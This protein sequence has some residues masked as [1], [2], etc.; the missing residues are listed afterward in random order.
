MK[1]PEE[2]REERIRERERERE[3]EGGRG[4]EG[5]GKRKGG[6]EDGHARYRCRQVQALT[7]LKRTGSPPGPPPASRAISCMIDSTSPLSE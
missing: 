2:E 1:T 4:K 6:R 5:E 7:V 3:R